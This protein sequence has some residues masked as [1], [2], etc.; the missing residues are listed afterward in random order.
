MWCGGGRWRMR[1]R[2]AASQLCRSTRVESID[3]TNIEI[4][5]GRSQGAS[6]PHTPIAGCAR[7]LALG[8]CFAPPPPPPSSIAGKWQAA[9]RAMI[10]SSYYTHAC[11]G[12]LLALACLLPAAK[13]IDHTPPPS[14]PKPPF[15]RPSTLKGAGGRAWGVQSIKDT[16][17][18]P[19]PPQ[20]F[21][22]CVRRC[23]P[24][25]RCNAPRTAERTQTVMLRIV[26]CPPMIIG[27]L[28]CSISSIGRSTDRVT[29]RGR[30]E[31]RST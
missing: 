1:W 21:C 14:R 30:V 24:L 13:A 9:T 10:N 20:P 2:T 5:S 29:G 11:S 7:G 12:A 4:G 8:V 31:E 27:G 15:Q 19:L 6:R 16:L 23:Q 28:S 26:R 18:L 3:S 25:A 17:P 22:S